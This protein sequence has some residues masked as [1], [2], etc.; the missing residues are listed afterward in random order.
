MVGRQLTAPIGRTRFSDF[1]SV[2]NLFR[3]P[4]AGR[5][6]QTIRLNLPETIWHKNATYLGPVWF[7]KY[8][9]GKMCEFA[10]I[11]LY[12]VGYA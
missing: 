7:Q 10:G 1:I 6:R 5:T 3:R 11:V 8:I 2:M 4:A 12:T 9:V